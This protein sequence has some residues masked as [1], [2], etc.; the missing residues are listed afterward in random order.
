MHYCLVYGII[1]TKKNILE[2]ENMKDIVSKKN[3]ITAGIITG[4]IFVVGLI[5]PSYAGIPL[6]FVA[7]AIGLYVSKKV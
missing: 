7:I 3:L 4:A 1:F 6:T 5:L 2:S